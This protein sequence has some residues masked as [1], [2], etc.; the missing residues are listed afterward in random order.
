[1]SPPSTRSTPPVPSIG[2]PRVLA[3]SSG[4][5]H[6]VQLCR[7]APAWRDVDLITACTAEGAPMPAQVRRHHRLPDATRWDRWALLKLTLQVGRLVLRERPHLIV[8]TGAAPGLLAL[9]WGRLIGAH[10]VWIDSLANVRNLSASGRAA[11]WIAHECLTQ[12]PHLQEGRRVAWKGS[13]W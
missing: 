11:R 7:V 6:W 8:T 9:A 2:M 3:L 12:W 1:M 5:G 10:T 4:G 13:V